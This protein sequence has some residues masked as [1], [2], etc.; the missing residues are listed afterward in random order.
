MLEERIVNNH[1]GTEDRCESSSVTRESD[2]T[3]RNFLQQ[4]MAVATGLAISSMLPHFAT[5]AWAREVTSPCPAGR[6][7]PD[8]NGDQEF[9]YYKDASGSNQNP[10]LKIRPIWRQGV[11]RTPDRCVTFRATMRASPYR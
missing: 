3:R 6:C 7:A 8:N 5:K 1:A 10:R 9:E 11:F 4:A 2:V